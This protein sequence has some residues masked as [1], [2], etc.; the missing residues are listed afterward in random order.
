MRAEQF[1]RF[2]RGCSDANVAGWSVATGWAAR[3]R[4]ENSCKETSDWLWQFKSC[5]RG[6]GVA[7]PGDLIAPRILA[8]ARL[9]SS[10]ARASIISG[11]FQ[12]GSRGLAP[13]EAAGKSVN[14][15]GS[16]EKDSPPLSRFPRLEMKSVCETKGTV[17]RNGRDVEIGF[18][19]FQSYLKQ[20]YHRNSLFLERNILH[21]RSSALR[22]VGSTLYTGEVLSFGLERFL[23]NLHTALAC[24]PDSNGQLFFLRTQEIFFFR[25]FKIY[26]IYILIL[27]K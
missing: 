16:F 20:R 7:T 27:L 12:T 5:E 11:K 9:E 8:A 19:F 4:G 23:S 1:R 14:V 6:G 17:R 2:I 24:I 18:Q 3:A 22:A 21:F 25:G 15:G 13:A 10:R 26:L